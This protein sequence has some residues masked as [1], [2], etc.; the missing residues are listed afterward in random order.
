MSRYLDRVRKDVLPPDGTEFTRSMPP[1]DIADPG[2][3][4]AP[5]LLKPT[6][7]GWS[8]VIA[9]ATLVVLGVGII[10]EASET[11][12]GPALIVVYVAGTGAM[13]GVSAAYHRFRWLPGARSLMSKLDHCTI[14]LAIAG[15]YTPMA[16]VTL[17][18][19]HRTSVLVTAWVGSAIG[20][21]LQWVPSHLPRW[22]FAAVYVVVGWA[23]L[24][25]IGQWYSGLGP[26]GFALVMAGGVAY[27]IGA[28]IYALKRPDPWPRVFGYHEVFHACT[29]VGAGLHYAAMAAVVVPKF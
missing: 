19:W 11:D 22:A 23:A 5:A 3:V 12:R 16:V 8:H 25:S 17:D 28:V 27:T 2:L 26:L 24:P 10:T 18:G 6:L 14:F 9:F 20:I 13:F 15:A 21:A 1:H 29:V 4:E 7:R